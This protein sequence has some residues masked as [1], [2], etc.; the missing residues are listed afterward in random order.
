MHCDDINILKTLILKFGVV[1][2]SGNFT[3]PVLTALLRICGLPYML[4]AR[5][6]KTL[7]YPLKHVSIPGE[8]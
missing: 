1:F 6:S 8:Q 7:R 2:V 4:H 5:T 3:E